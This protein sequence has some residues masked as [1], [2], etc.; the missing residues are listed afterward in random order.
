MIGA[1]PVPSLQR[2]NQQPPSSKQDY[3]M[4]SFSLLYLNSQGRYHTTMYL[5]VSMSP[6]LTGPDILPT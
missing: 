1:L 4:N 6:S 3:P 5:N 2:W